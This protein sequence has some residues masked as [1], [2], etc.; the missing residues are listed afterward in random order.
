MTTRRL[1][2]WLPL[3]GLAPSIVSG[4]V[5]PS[6]ASFR[7]SLKQQTWAKPNGEDSNPFSWDRPSKSDLYGE[8]E[9]LNLLNIHQQLSGSQTQP[10]STENTR[11]E[12]EQPPNMPNLH[13]SIMQSYGEDTM[14]KLLD[15]HDSL[16][17]ERQEEPSNKDSALH[18]QIRQTVGEIQQL[19]SPGSAQSN[20]WMDEITKQSV[21]QI[22]AIAS[23][24][25]GTL[26]TSRQTMHPRTKRAIQRAMESVQNSG[27][28]SK[29]RHFFPA[30]GKSPEGAMGSLG[31]EVADLLQNSPGV[32]LQGLYCLDGKGNILFEKKLPAEALAAAESL[33]IDNQISM[34]SYDGSNLFTT[35]MTDIVLELT[36]LYGEPRASCLPSLTQHEPGMHK[37][38]YMDYNVE[39]LAREIRPQLEAVAE[40][41]G[42]CVTQA[43]PTMLE[44]L[45]AGCSKAMG[46]QKVCEFLGIDAQTQLLAIGDA[47]NDG[48]MLQMAAIGVAV[49]N[50][51]PA[52]QEASDF[53]LEESNDEGGAG[54]AMEVFGFGDGIQ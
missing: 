34:V 27:S 33:A 46:V 30:T 9:L 47:E 8:D 41:Y 19:D 54:V 28:T 11:N 42:A 12:V 6:S 4:F 36:D 38:L 15:L 24:V 7:E 43:M 22:T 26:L 20:D 53:L 18:E 52:A 45:P 5:S 37:L 35:E 50:A 21:N 16:E 39:R 40:K 25:D 14:K 44:L 10:E 49:G 3:T 2:C 29:I 31:K 48:G 1:L 51:C 23:D 32:F 13:E 17:K